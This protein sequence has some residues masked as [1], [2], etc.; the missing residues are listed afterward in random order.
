[1]LGRTGL[2]SH[3]HCGDRGEGGLVARR[4]AAP[5]SRRK[6]TSSGPPSTTCTPNACA[7]FAR[8]WP[9]SPSTAITCAWVSKAIG[10][11]SSI[12]GSS[13]SSKWPWRHAPTR[14]LPPSC[15]PPKKHSRR[16]WYE[17]S[18]E[19][20]PEWKRKGEKFVLGF[21]LSRYVMEGMAI[22]FPHSQGN[23]A[24]QT[25]AALSR[26]EAQGTRGRGPLT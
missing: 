13:P 10:R 16:E 15:F 22:S 4:H 3:H 18:L 23:G 2:R 6:W 19:L 7:P 26:R 8:P 9:R 5:L 25:R 24:R 14:N 12:P 17:A 1:V 11:T 21:D 20:F